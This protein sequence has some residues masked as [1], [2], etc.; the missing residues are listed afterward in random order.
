MLLVV[1]YKVGE[2]LANGMLRPFLVDAG[3]DLADIGWLLGT[4]GFMAGCWARCAGGAL[5]GRSGG[6]RRSSSSASCRPSPSPATL[7][8]LSNPG[9]PAL[10]VPVRPP[11]TSRAAWRPRHCSRG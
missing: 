7:L 8:A 2:A 1:V 6:G 5:V 11:S 9:L 10:N 4:V 3:L